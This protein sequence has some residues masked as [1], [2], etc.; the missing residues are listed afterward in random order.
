MS[1]KILAGVV[2]GL[3]VVAAGLMYYV[4]GTPTYSLYQLR[5][6]LQ[7]GDREA[8][9]HHFDVKQ[10][11]ETAVSKAVTGSGLPAGPGIVSKKAAQFI[12]PAAERILTARIDECLNDPSRVPIASMSLQDIRI[13]SGAAHVTLSNDEQTAVLVMTQMSDR[14]WKVVSIDLAAAGIPFSYDEIR[15]EAE[16]SMPPEMPGTNRPPLDPSALGMPRR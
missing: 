8:F 1:W 7:R 5:R 4:A 13:D 2:I 14:H 16:K 3:L 9:Y 10:V 11:I 6:A 15:V 12:M